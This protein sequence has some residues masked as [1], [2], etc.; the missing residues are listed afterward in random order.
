ML[1]RPT[2][3]Q[4][5]RLLLVVQSSGGY[6]LNLISTQKF[7]VE[8]NNNLK[9]YII[10]K[11]K[12]LAQQHLLTLCEEMKR[13]DIWVKLS[14]SWTYNESVKN[15]VTKFLLLLYQLLGPQQFTWS[16]DSNSADTIFCKALV[17][18]SILLNLCLHFPERCPCQPSSAGLTD[19]IQHEETV[20]C[21]SRKL[22][23]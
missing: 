6:L 14:L 9:V 15:T 5:L 20:A 3:H 4:Q 16:V 1:P 2:V 22:K 13:N 12:L 18:L 17:V 19:E 10:M 11:K 21:L 7:F 8:S 23:L